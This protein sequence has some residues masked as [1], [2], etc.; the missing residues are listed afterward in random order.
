MQLK[1]RYTKDMRLN[2][3]LCRCCGSETFE[4][5]ENV[6]VSPFFAKYGLQL[7]VFNGLP[8]E[9][10]LLGRLKGSH[11]LLSIFFR[12][13]LIILRLFQLPFRQTILVPYGYC[14]SCEFIAPWFEIS[15][16]QLLDY[17][18]FYLSDSYKKNRL[19]IEKGY[20]GVF[21]THGSRAEFDLRKVDYSNFISE[22]LRNLT[23]TLNVNKLRMLDFGGGDSGIQPDPTLVDCTIFDVGAQFDL[24]KDFEKFHFV[25]A[26]HVLEHV[27]SPLDTF[28]SAYQKCI[29]GGLVYVEVPMEHPGFHHGDHVILPYACD[30]HINKFSLKSIIKMGDTSGGKIVLAIQDSIETIHRGE[31]QVLRLIVRKV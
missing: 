10:G 8:K 25:Q 11:K 23:K 20:R 28:K 19:E 29:L 14:T 6:R 16:D 24:E 5:K 2:T 3:K 26:L 15:N 13:L 17:Y 22:T 21:E 1:L 18:T 30:E 7:E 12:P 31:T 4:R 9:F 27:G